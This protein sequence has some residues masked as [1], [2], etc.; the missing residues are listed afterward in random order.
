MYRSDGSSWFACVYVEQ[1]AADTR[2]HNNLGSAPNTA[3]AYMVYDGGSGLSASH[4]LL[5]GAARFVNPTAGDFNL[6]AGSLAIDAGLD[7]GLPY[8][9]LGNPRFDDPAV[10]NQG[11]GTSPYYDIGAL[12]RQ[13]A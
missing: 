4:N 6:Q 2:V 11:T 7:I 8:D 10:P 13:G 5:T 1:V 9:C 3:N 12:E